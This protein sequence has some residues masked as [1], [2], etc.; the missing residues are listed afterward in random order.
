MAYNEYLADRIMQN[1]ESRKIKHI[2]KKMFGGVCLMVDDKML[3][4]V[5]KKA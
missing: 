2:E 1:L 3:V 5:M 4:G